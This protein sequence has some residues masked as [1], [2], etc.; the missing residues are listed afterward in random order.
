MD[1]A[2][3]TTAAEMTGGK[4]YTIDDTDQIVANLPTGRRVPIEN[5]PPIPLWNQWWLLSLFLGCVIT[6][7]VLR[8][9]KGM[10]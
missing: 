3:L 1:R 9:R 8:K 7:W 6:E 5:L 10:L 2:A 4:F